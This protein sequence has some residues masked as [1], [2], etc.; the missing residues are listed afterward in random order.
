MRITF[1]AVCLILATGHAVAAPPPSPPP[2]LPWARTRPLSASA[3]ALIETA[4]E[5]S[6][7]VQGLLDDLERTDLVVY[8]ADAMP[9]AF[10]GPKSAMTLVS[11]VTAT[12]YVMIRIDSMRLPLKARIAALGHEL[13]HALEVAAAPEVKDSAGLA[14]LYRRIGWETTAGRFESRGAQ[15]ATFQIARQLQRGE[16]PQRVAQV[17]GGTAPRGVGGPW[18]Y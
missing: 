11:G 1:I 7:I 2:S 10:V 14:A 16:K 9:G 6:A 17:E 12:R 3:L 5:R 15:E 13:Y 18:E 4:A 8:I